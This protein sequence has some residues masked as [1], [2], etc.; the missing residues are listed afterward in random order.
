LKALPVLLVDLFAVKTMRAKCVDAAFL[1]D[2]LEV[3][4]RRVSTLGERLPIIARQV[5]DEL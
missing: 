1:D 2:G 5:H 4:L 3:F